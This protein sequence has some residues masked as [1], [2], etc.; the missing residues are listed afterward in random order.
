MTIQSHVCE[1][2]RRMFVSTADNNYI[3]ARSA[4]FNELDFDFYWLSLHALE[5]YFK[6]ILL[7]NGK[8][9]KDHSHDLLKLHAAVMK[10]DHRLPIGPLVDPKIDD[11]FW[12]NWP[13]ERYLERLNRFGSADNRY[14]TYG[15]NLL[16]EDLFKVDQLVWSVRRC[17]HPLRYTIDN[18]QREIDH[19]S[20]LIRD[21]NHWTMTGVSLP[22]EKLLARP[23][24]N[25]HRAA[26]LRLNMAFAPKATHVVTSWRISS[27]NSPLAVWFERLKAKH[28]SR[29]RTR[30]E[31]R[32]AAEVLTWAADHIRFNRSDENEIRAALAQRKRRR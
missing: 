30:D 20:H 32:I 15:Y 11:V 22:I 5:K 31:R 23:T 10:L 25:A 19:V 12:R 13:V 8:K 3:L 18:G 4:F 21:K 1:I 7:M 9:A 29:T 26:F 16:L 6:A 27:T 17:C 14:A 28:G 2:A 24:D